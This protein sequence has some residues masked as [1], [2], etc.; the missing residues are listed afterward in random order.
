M[1]PEQKAEA[2]TSLV[3]QAGLAIG[4]IYWTVRKFFRKPYK[5]TKTE[6]SGIFK[7]P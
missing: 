1:T 7:K 6:D 5:S 2:I 4:A 3:V